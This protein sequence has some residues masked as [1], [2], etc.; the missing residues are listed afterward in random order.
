ML[1]L[2]HFSS[3]ELFEQ[4][5]MDQSWKRFGFNGFAKRTESFKKAVKY[6]RKK[7]KIG[8]TALEFLWIV[9]VI[10]G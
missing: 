8:I 7:T 6:Q 4:K 3:H 1:L 10:Y 2:D 5:F 9:D